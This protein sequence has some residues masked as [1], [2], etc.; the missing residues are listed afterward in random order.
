MQYVGSSA[1]EAAATAHELKFNPQYFTPAELGVHDG[2][3]PGRMLLLSIKGTILDVSAGVDFYPPGKTYHC[4]TGRDCSRAFSRSSLKPED[5]HNDLSGAT[6]D[7]LKVLDD[8]FASAALHV[9]ASAPP[10]P[11]TASALSPSPVRAELSEKYPTVGTLLP[12]ATPKAAAGGAAAAA[13]RAAPAGAGS[14]EGLEGNGTADADE[15]R[16]VSD[17]AA[18]GAGAEDDEWR[19]VS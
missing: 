3:A 1:S 5:M 15:W 9:A 7:E 19:M 12:D 16:D 18:A 17:A 10:A 11:P 2:S 8:W 6:D 13:G 14:M 4:L